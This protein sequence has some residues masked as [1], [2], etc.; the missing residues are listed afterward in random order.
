MSSSDA[1]AVADARPEYL[2]E[3]PVHLGNF[4]VERQAGERAISAH[5]AADG[6]IAINFAQLEVANSLTVALMIA[7][8]RLAKKRDCDIR[9]TNLPT[10]LQQVVEFSGLVD[11]LPIEAA[12]S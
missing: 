10:A 4:N 12:A 11:V 3:G 8:Y 7:W 9:F 1:A 6:I 5:S 2:V